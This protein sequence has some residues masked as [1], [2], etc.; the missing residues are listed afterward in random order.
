MAK[1]RITGEPKVKKD[2]YI[3]YSLTLSTLTPIFLAKYW[4]T[5]KADFSMAEIIFFIRDIFKVSKVTR[6][7]DSQTK[8]KQ[9][10]LWSYIFFYSTFYKSLS[11]LYF[12]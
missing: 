8:I 2:V 3:K 5:P 12:F 1:Y 7:S 11:Q 4:Q 6:E 10:L 9:N